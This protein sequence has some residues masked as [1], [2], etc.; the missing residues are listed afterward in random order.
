V[1]PGGRRAVAGAALVLAMACSKHPRAGEPGPVVPPN[2]PAAVAGTEG[3]APAAAPRAL[4]P[5]GL[6]RLQV[7]EGRLAAAGAGR[8]RVETPK[9]RAVA[10]AFRR[11]T[12]GL[13]FTYLGPTA[14]MSPLSS[15]EQRRQLGLKLKA[16]DGCNLVYVMWRLAPVPG[17]VVQVKQN[18]AARTSAE[19]GNAGYRT[20]RPARSVPP[21]AL[22]PGASHVLAARL[23]GTSLAVEIDGAPVWE[24]PVDAAAAALEG[25]IG[26]RTDNVRCDLELLGAGE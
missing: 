25:P 26:V 4:V 16:R 18:P 22:V 6:E 21:P 12:A 19:C 8:L 1:N 24:G 2:R 14:T 20:V 11:A 9:L 7:T 10:P 23:E 15:G 5:I 17:V 3:R 13:R